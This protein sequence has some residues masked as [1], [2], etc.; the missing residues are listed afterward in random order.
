[1][2]IPPNT[3]MIFCNNIMLSATG[4]Y[5]NQHRHYSYLHHF[6]HQDMFI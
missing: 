6:L 5:Y 3:I 2:D 4:A 1:M